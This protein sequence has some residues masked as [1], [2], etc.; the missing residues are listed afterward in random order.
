[1][2]GDIRLKSKVTDGCG[3]G[4]STAVR[5]LT[6]PTYKV[7]LLAGMAVA[8]LWCGMA[9]GT[10]RRGSG[11]DGNMPDQAAENGNPG[12]SVLSGSLRLAGSSSMEKLSSVLAEGFMEQYSFVTVTVEYTGSSA[13][14]EA[15]INGSADIGNSSRKLKEE[16]RAKG[17]VEHV[18]A[19]D[20]IAVCVDP[21]NP[22]KELTRQ[23]LTAIYTGRITN[24]SALG[25][26]DVPIVVIG[27]EAGSGTRTAFE[28][29]LGIED[30]C[31]YANELNSA[32][33]V[34]ARVAS[35]PGAIGYLSVEVMTDTVSAIS[36]DGAEPTPENIENGSY[37]LCRPFLMITKG[38][39]SDQNELVRAW[40]AY[41]EERMAGYGRLWDGGSSDI[42]K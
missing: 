4:I 40:F 42:G 9:G 35:T 27:H 41:M 34:M 10:G 15:V 30:A 31:S 22:V 16:E 25:G 21:A 36:L 14:I 23:Q 6:R 28:E 17:A 2:M 18:V 1:M 26:E 13:G 32:G 7:L 19:M 39:L 11:G 5:V 38:E 3:G 33:A 29:L 37:P 12:S 24:W 8:A 20:G